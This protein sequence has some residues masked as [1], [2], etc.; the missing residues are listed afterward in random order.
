MKLEGKRVL[1]TGGGSGIGLALAEH[2]AACANDV[3]IAGRDEDKLARVCQVSPQL[4]RVR[5]DVTSETDAADGLGWVERELGGLD[6]LVNSAGVMHGG[7]LGGTGAAATATEELE[8]NLGGTVRV[9]RLALPLLARSTEAGVV[10][11]SSAVALTAVPGWAV[12]AA[13]KAALH[14]LARSLRRELGDA[15]IGVFEVLPPVVDTELAAGLAVAKMPASEVADVVLAGLRRDRSQIA[16]GP[17]RALVP[18]ARVAPRLAD[19]V[20]I[21]ALGGGRG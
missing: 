4:R 5:M 6:L 9:T 17:I 14:S 1:I 16:V 13:S 8:V 20:V 11:I 21:R 2:L 12:Y 10:L 7:E 18:M 19:R 15:G 3:V